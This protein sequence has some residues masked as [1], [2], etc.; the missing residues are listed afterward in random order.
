MTIIGILLLEMFTD[1]P[2]Q[3]QQML[4]SGY[5][6]EVLK[7]IKAIQDLKVTLV[8]RGRKEKRET[9]EQSVRWDRQVLQT[10]NLPKHLRSQNLHPERHLRRCLARWRRQYQRYLISSIRIR[11]STTRQRRLPAHMRLM[12]CRQTRTLMEHW[13][14]RFLI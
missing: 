4:R 8:H 12:Q 3:E 14:S 11:W 10:Q 1:A 2:L 7:E 9:Q 6:L 5:L 13:R